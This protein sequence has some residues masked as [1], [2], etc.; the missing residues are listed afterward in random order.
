MVNPLRE[1]GDDPRSLGKQH[2]EAF[3]RGGVEAA[4]AGD[5]GD[6]GGAG[7]CHR[8]RGVE[9]LGVRVDE[10]VILDAVSMQMVEQSI[11]QPDVGAGSDG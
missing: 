7:L 3:D 6:A 8:E 11:E 5:V 4:A 1:E 2:I 10:L 9:S